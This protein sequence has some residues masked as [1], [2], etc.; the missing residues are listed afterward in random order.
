M[1]AR[2]LAAPP[3]RRAVTPQRLHHLLG[4]AAVEGKGRTVT[5]FRTSAKTTAG[6]HQHGGPVDGIEG[7]A[8]DHLDAAFHLLLD[9][10]AFD[11]A[12]P[13]ALVARFTSSV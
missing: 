3:S 5:S 12:L 4:V 2:A 13:L 8:H 7:H 1:S 9:L 6:P 11:R 10:D